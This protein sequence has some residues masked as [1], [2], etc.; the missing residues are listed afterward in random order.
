MYAS[1]YLVGPREGVPRTN[2]FDKGCTGKG[3]RANQARVSAL[4]EALERYSGVYQGDEARVRGSKDELGAAAL[5][6]GELL[7]FSEAQYRE[8]AHLNAQAAARRQGVPEPLD[9]G[10]SIDRTPA[11]S[12]ALARNGPPL[13][14][15]NGPGSDPRSWR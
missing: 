15:Q 14:A 10:T 4:C 11:W 13:L 3:R 12:S 2:V 9:A 7:N 1:G 6:L 5:S 8:R